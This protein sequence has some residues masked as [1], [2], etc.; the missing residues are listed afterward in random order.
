MFIPA[1]FYSQGKGWVG[2]INKISYVLG[3]GDFF[4]VLSYLQNIIFELVYLQN[5]KSCEIERKNHLFL[6]VIFK[7]IHIMC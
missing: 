2:V 4:T 5:K 6:G 7:L 3:F 1:P